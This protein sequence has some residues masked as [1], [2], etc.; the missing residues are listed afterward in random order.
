MAY[1]ISLKRS[2]SSGQSRLLFGLTIGVVVRVEV[3][4]LVADVVTVDVA[5]DDTVDVA[6]DVTVEMHRPHNCGQFCRRFKTNEVS[7]L[8][9][10]HNTLSPLPGTQ[11]SASRRPLQTGQV[12]V[13]A[14]V[15]V[16]TVCEVVVVVVVGMHALHTAGQSS[17]H[18]SCSHSSWLTPRQFSLA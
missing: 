12:V 2:M 5:V 4:V 1:A 17:F 14:V 9:G 10:A 11:W 7:S 16:L 3:G 6:V 15:V 18:T 8:P 13:V